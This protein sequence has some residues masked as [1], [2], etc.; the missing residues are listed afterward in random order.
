MHPL[1]SRTTHLHHHICRYQSDLWFVVIKLVTSI[2][3]LLNKTPIN[4]YSKKTSHIQ[5]TYGSEYVA[6]KTAVKQSIDLHTTLLYLGV[7]FC[8]HSYF[9]GNDNFIEGSSTTSDTNY[10]RNML[11]C[12][13][14]KSG[15]LLI[16]VWY[17]STSSTL[18]LQTSLAN[19]G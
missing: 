13:S 18:T 12:F 10:L 15:K 11:Y 3:Y 14:I 2:L 17:N 1:L 5:D 19:I 7:P 8:D 9:F 16:Q 6:A 4:W